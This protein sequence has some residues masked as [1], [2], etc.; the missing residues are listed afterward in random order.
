MFFFA[1]LYQYYK[2][3]NVD[4]CNIFFD[5]NLVINNLIIIV[6]DKKLNAIL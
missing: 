4:S 5:F 6:K 3:V 2:S 1:G